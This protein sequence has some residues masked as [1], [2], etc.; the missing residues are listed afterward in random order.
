MELLSLNF[1]K[2][3]PAARIT[4]KS[5]QGRFKLRQRVRVFELAPKPVAG[6][7]IGI[8]AGESLAHTGSSGQ[9]ELYIARTSLGDVPVWPE[10]LQAR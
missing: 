4:N 10:F 3:R 1:A 9:G 8:V 6:I 7:I 5:A 2:A